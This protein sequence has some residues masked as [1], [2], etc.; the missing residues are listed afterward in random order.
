[1]TTQIIEQRAYTATHTQLSND[2]YW[3]VYA[4]EDGFVRWFG[5]N[6]RNWWDNVAPLEHTRTRV[7]KVT[8]RKFTID[9]TTGEVTVSADAPSIGMAREIVGGQPS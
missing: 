3:K 7:G 1:M 6:D 9:F 5:Y 8:G 2:L 4:G